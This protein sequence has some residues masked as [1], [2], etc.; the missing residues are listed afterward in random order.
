[1]IPI[2][3]KSSK[4]LPIKEALQNAQKLATKG[5]RTVIA[6]INDILVCVTQK[7]NIDEAL[8][9]YNQRANQK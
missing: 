8:A 7:T 5:K 9:L 1:M 6:D 4:D 3:Y 2:T